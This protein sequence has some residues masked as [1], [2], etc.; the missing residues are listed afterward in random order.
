MVFDALAPIL[1][2]ITHGT[3][4]VDPNDVIMVGHSVRQ[5]PGNTKSTNKTFCVASIAIDAGSTTAIAS[6]YE[7]THSGFVIREGKHLKRVNTPTPPKVLEA[8]FRKYEEW[9]N[10]NAI[11]KR[12]SEIE[13]PSDIAS[14]VKHRGHRSEALRAAKEKQKQEEAKK[15][16]AEDEKKKAPTST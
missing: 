9:K 3:I 5:K 2:S 16:A 14:A 12:Q 4:N 1:T 7:N 8:T 11:A 15:Q 6:L 10:Q 13:T